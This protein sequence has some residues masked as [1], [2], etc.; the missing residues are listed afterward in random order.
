MILTAKNKSRLYFVIALLLGVVI[1]ASLIIYGLSKNMVY[2]YTPTQV[3]NKEAPIN[4]SIRVG[5]MVVP[6]SIIKSKSSLNV[7]FQIND[8]KNT[9]SI[10]YDGLLPDL[11]GENQG[12]VVTGSLD[13]KSNFV[14]NEVLAKHDENYMPPE[15]AD[16]MGI[17][18]Q[19]IND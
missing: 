8:L 2:F 12:V 5:G 6:G 13:S 9:I 18:P 3:I 19:N 11:F 4:K 10:S 7:I 17:K 16:M 1:A 14:A 15:V